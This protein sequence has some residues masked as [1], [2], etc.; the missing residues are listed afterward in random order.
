MSTL[1]PNWPTPTPL[2]QWL[3]IQP[4]AGL[5]VA[6]T[7]PRAPARPATALLLLA[8][9]YSM[10]RSAQLHYAGTRFGAPLISMGWVNVLNAVDLLVLSRVSFEAQKLW[11]F[12]KYARSVDGSVAKLQV[13]PPHPPPTPKDSTS[14]EWVSRLRWA[15]SIAFNY[16]RIDTPWEIRHLPRFDAAVPGYVPSRARFLVGA[17]VKVVVAVAVIQGCTMETADANLG[18]AV[19]LLPEAREALLPFAFADTPAGWDGVWRR[20]LLRALFCLSF[21]IVGRATII[22][23]YNVGAIVAVALGLYEPVMWPPVAG[24]LWEG[25]SVRR[26]WGITWHQT[27]RQLLTSNADFLLSLLRISPSGR[28][29]WTLRALLAFTVSGVIHLFMDVGFGVPMAKSGALWFFC[30]QIVGVVIESI[31]RDLTRPLRARMNPGVKRMIGYVWVALFMLWTVPI[32]INPILIQ[33][34]SDGVRMMSPFLCFGSW[35]I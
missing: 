14:K 3:L 35:K 32:W 17:V 16:R 6:F 5:V 29:G 24:S 18:Q 10:Q 7:A 25:W 2:I 20:M 4:L 27:F 33:L 21:G 30:L 34:Y 12:A 13:Q 11:E 9:A 22:A 19:A 8:L 15:L 28:L 23:S 31:A 26:F 1:P